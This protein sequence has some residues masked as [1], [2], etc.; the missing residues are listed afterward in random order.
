[1]TNNSSIDFKQISLVKIM[2]NLSQCYAL[3]M[4]SMYVENHQSKRNDYDH[5]VFEPDYSSVFNSYNHHLQKGLKF[6]SHS[7]RNNCPPTF[8]SG[9]NNAQIGDQPIVRLVKNGCWIVQLVTGMSVIHLSM[10]VQLMRNPSTIPIFLYCKYH[11]ILLAIGERVT[12]FSG[13]NQMNFLVVQS[14]MFIALAQVQVQTQ[15]Q[16]Q[17]QLQQFIHKRK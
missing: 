12:I 1:M 10:S 5:D 14:L 15:V 4:N 11:L 3:E 17:V 16:V 7:Y 9:T 2:K 8:G 6:N 13:S